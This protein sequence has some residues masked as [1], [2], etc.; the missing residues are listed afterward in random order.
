MQ[1]KLNH[2]LMILQNVIVHWF[3]TKITRLSIRLKKIKISKL[4]QFGIAVKE[5]QYYNFP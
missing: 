3:N 5:S 1:E 2:F 4:L